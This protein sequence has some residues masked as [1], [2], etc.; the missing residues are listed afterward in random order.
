MKSLWTL[1]IL[2]TLPLALGCS[3]DDNATDPPPSVEDSGTA[4]ADESDGTDENMQPEDDPTANIGDGNENP[5][6]TTEQ[7]ADLNLPL[8]KQRQ[9]AY[10]TGQQVDLDRVYLNQPTNV[11]T[12]AFG[13]P[14]GKNASG[15]FVI[16]FYDNM[17]VDWQGTNY[18]RIN[19]I[20]AKGRVVK[21][22]IDPRSAK[23]EEGVEPDTEPTPE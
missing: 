2:L 17:K 19:V 11:L 22:T 5:S 8:G 18:T 13:M 4:N 6:E 15:Q 14:S 20:T 7:G 23:G 3:K 21:I 9:W 1:S 16:W 10:A 12:T